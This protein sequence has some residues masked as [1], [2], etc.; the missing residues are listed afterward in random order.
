MLPNRKHIISAVQI[1]LVVIVI[2]AILQ[3]FEIEAPAVT[4]FTLL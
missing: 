3:H 2:N 1:L 4:K